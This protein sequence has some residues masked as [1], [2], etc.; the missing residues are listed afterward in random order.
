MIRKAACKGIVTT[1][2]RSSTAR[3]ALTFCY[4]ALK[5][6]GV[7]RR[8]LMPSEAKTARSAGTAAEKTN[9]VA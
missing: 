3:I 4:S 6:D 5:I 7:F 2:T 8:M 9:D 1:L